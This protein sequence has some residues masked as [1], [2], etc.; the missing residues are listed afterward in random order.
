METER[1]TYNKIVRSKTERVIREKGNLPDM[2]EYNT[3][4]AKDVEVLKELFRKK[5]TEEVD[6]LL[7][8]RASDEILEEAGDVID[9]IKTYLTLFHFRSQHLDAIS[10]AK[11]VKRGSFLNYETVSFLRHVDN[12]V[13]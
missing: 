2:V 10:K 13:G 4:K 5:I 1:K 12:K 7:E 9:V 8:A 6:E 3:S 11:E